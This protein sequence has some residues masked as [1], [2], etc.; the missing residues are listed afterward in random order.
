VTKPPRKL[1]RVTGRHVGAGAVFKRQSDAW[2][3]IAAA[4]FLRWMMRT[5]IKQVPTEL[6]R[7][8]WEWEWIDCR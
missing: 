2:V 1:L 7:R 5:P 6:R 3:C 4:P 8:G